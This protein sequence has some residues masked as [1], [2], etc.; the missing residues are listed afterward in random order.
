MKKNRIL[1]ISKKLNL[2]HVGSNVSCYPILKTIYKLKKPDDLVVLDNGHAALALYCVIEENG[3][4]NAEEIYNHHGVH[5]DRCSDCGLDSS[6]GSLGHGLGIA[7][8]LALAVRTRTIFVVVSD[9]SMAEGSNWEALRLIQDLGVTNIRIHVNA[10]GFSA[11]SLVDTNTLKRR[12]RAF[13]P[14]IVHRTHNG[15]GFE[16]IEGHYKKI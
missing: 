8:G 3:G 13:T 1:E 10:N 15:E 2:S 4:R 6:A 14:V 5:P 11:T 9:G 16:G 7:I 12:M